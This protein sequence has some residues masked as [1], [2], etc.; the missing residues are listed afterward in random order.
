MK[1]LRPSISREVLVRKVSEGFSLWVTLGNKTDTKI[2]APKMIR[3]PQ[4]MM[5][6]VIRIHYLK[7]IRKAQSA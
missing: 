6:G 2:T 5:V 1:I 7:L 4:I 3:H